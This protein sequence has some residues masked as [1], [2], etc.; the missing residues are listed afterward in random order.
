MFRRAAGAARDR[1]PWGDA[2]DNGVDEGRTDEERGSR[3]EDTAVADDV[4]PGDGLDGVSECRTLADAVDS[5]AL[6]RWLPPAW[7]ATTEVTKLGTDPVTEVLVLEGR[8]HRVLLDPVQAVEPAGQVTCHV[9]PADSACRRRWRTFDSL[10]AALAAALGRL[11]DLDEHVDPV[12]PAEQRAA[13]AEALTRD[14]THEGT[15]DPVS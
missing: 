15:P 4:A 2:A 10:H 1:A 5:D 13:R 3:T 14:R 11:T 7:S 12:A 6:D 8:G 9:R